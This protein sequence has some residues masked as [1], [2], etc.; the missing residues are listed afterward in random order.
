MDGTIFKLAFGPCI[1]VRFGR[2]GMPE[3][4]GGG[5]VGGVGGLPPTKDGFQETK[6]RN[7]VRDSVLLKFFDKRYCLFSFI[8]RRGT[9]KG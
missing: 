9:R 4:V 1:G 3:V 6:E 2:C 5:G 7:F 8:F